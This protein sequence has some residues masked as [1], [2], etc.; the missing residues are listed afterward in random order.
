MKQPDSMDVDAIHEWIATNDTFCECGHYQDWG[1]NAIDRHVLLQSNLT[2]HDKIVFFVLMSLENCEL[3]YAS[4]DELARMAAISIEEVKVALVN[5]ERAGR[6]TY[7]QVNGK[8]TISVVTPAPR[9]EYLKSDQA[10][11]YLGMT[12]L[13]LKAL[14]TGGKVAQEGEYF[15]VLEL[16]NWKRYNALFNQLTNRQLTGVDDW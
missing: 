8:K 7:E 13:E 12:G 2:P 16:Y 15:S 1:V 3:V 6:L 5:L 14:S 11:A 10:A 4:E 9:F